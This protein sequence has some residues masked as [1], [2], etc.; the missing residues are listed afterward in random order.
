MP[1]IYRI[2]N[3]INGKSYIG[4]TGKDFDRRW[5]SHIGHLNVNKHTNKEL[6][7]DWNKHGKTAFVF[8]IIEEGVLQDNLIHRERHWTIEA[9]REGNC[10]NMPEYNHS[11]SSL[12]TSLL[13]DEIALLRTARDELSQARIAYLQALEEVSVEKYRPVDIVS[14]DIIHDLPLFLSLVISIYMRFVS[15]EIKGLPWSVRNLTGKHFLRDNY[16]GELTQDEAAEVASMMMRMKI[17]TDR[18][19]RSAGKWSCKSIEDIVLKVLAHW[20]E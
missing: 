12:P 16:I 5:R 15:K 13:Y 14:R 4:S 10:Y 3:T 19:D 1:G 17:I 20:S 8:E 7:I 18:S 11:G 2:R 9:I 6:Q